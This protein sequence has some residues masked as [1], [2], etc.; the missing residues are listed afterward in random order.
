MKLFGNS[1]NSKHSHNADR[2]RARYEDD[3][4]DDY[5][6]RTPKKS[7]KRKR[8]KG[9]ALKKFLIAVLIL[10]ILGGG[11][12]AFLK[13][14]IR[15]PEQGGEINPKNDTPVSNRTKQNYTFLLLGKDKVS[16]NTDTIM[17]GKFDSENYKLDIVSIPRDTL[18]NVYWRTKKA[19][20][21][22]DADDIDDTLKRFA[23]ILGYKVDFYAVVDLEAFTQLVNSI[24]GVWYDVPDVEGGGKGMN[25]DDPYQNLSIHLKPGYQLLTGE[26]AIGVVRY[27]KGY[28]NQDIGRISS[29]QNFLMAA[30]KQILENKNKISIA[31][32]TTI[33]LKYVNT[34]LDN[35]QCIWFGKEMMKMD[36]ENIVFHTMPGKY[37]DTVHGVSYVTIEVVEWLEMINTYINP[38]DVNIE[39][40]NLNILTRDSMGRLYATS[41]L[42]GGDYAD[43]GWGN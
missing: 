37:D 26:Q 18:V 1:K 33:F 4:Y 5:Y 16:G 43:E 17:V 15:P 21:I 28:T 32:I 39:A 34:N 24:G 13:L 7:K 25:Y 27:R 40:G 20:T 38:F 12:Y 22:Y 42:Y 9:G 2:G 30:A 3:Y 41:G 14:Y 31:D 36:I 23:D 29:Q 10:G 11:G 35:G 8:K 19:N 6:E